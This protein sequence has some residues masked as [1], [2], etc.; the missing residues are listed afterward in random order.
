MTNDLPNR[1]QLPHKVPSWVND[2]S[3]F[4]VT[5]CT[6]PKGVNQLCKEETS[7]QIWN[8]AFHYMNIHKW[9]IHYLLLMPDHVHVLL[10]L[11][12][13]FDLEKTVS[14]W[15]RYTSREYNIKWQRDFFDHRLRDNE[16][17]ER[18]AEYISMN[19]VRAGLIDNPENWP[20]YWGFD[21]SGRAIR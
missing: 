8:S 21:S 16:S 18:K 20:Y 2:N 1:K 15:K 17:F 6:N 12:P 14:S 10:S 4:F 5:I 13:K 3:I 11:S 7:L 19:P 9:W